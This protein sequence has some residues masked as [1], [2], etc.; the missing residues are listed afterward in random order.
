MSV[1]VVLRC[2]VAAVIAA[3]CVSGAGAYIH[4]PPM[5]AQKMCKQ[6]HHIRLLKVTKHDKEKG[7]IVFEVAETLKG[8]KSR[9]TSFQHVLRADAEGVQPVLD[10]IADGKTAV[11]FTI[12]G[13]A[14]ACGYVFIDEYC[15][16]V[17]Y[18]RAGKFWLVI[19]GEPGLSACYHGSTEE[20]RK[21]VKDILAGKDVKVPTKD[22][23]AKED[24]EKRNKQVN[25]VLKKNR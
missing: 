2:V 1:R 15:Y 7:V 5:T 14:I 18:N 24:R 11:M 6:S 8:E 22:P 13:G 9:I 23:A 3:V 4:F 20:L 16:S 25:D 17:D 10:W 12:E 21:A 19:R